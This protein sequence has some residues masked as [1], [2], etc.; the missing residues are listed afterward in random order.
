MTLSGIEIAILEEEKV[1]GYLLAA[2]HPEGAGRASFFHAH[3][4]RREDWQ[5]LAEALQDHE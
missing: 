1:T 4:F 5:A 3:G 2:D